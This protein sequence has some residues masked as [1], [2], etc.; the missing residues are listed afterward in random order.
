MSNNHHASHPPKKKIHQDWRIIAAAVVMMIAMI[1]YVLTLDETTAPA[2]PDA[3]GQAGGARRGTGAIR[4]GDIPVA[5]GPAESVTCGQVRRHLAG[6]A[7]RREKEAL[8]RR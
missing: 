6:R 2:G 5:T 7:V 8:R 4:S 3:G 1:M